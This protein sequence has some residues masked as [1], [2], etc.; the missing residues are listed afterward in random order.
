MEDSMKVTSYPLT[1]AAS[2][3]LALT[4]WAQNPSSSQTPQ[5]WPG[6]QSPCSSGG[7]RSPGI[8]PSSSQTPQS[9][10]ESQPPYTPGGVRN[11]GLNPCDTTEGQTQPVMDSM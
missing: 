4:V 6:S 5:S 11:P 1:V 2:A 7:V 8:N 3:L 10:P 9:R